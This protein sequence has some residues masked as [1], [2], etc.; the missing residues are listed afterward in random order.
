MEQSK[1]EKKLSEDYNLISIME[2]NVS[3]E[4]QIRIIIFVYTA[5]MFFIIGFFASVYLHA[6]Y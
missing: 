4:K 1:Y 6:N 2:S 5:I 3:M